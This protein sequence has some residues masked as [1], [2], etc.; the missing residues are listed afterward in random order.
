MTG[1][2]ANMKIDATGLPVVSEQDIIELMY[3]GHNSNELFV[4]DQILFENVQRAVKDL[5]LPM[6]FSIKMHEARTPDEMT[7]CWRLPEEYANIEIESW[8]ADRIST[9]EQALRVADEL[10]LYQAGGLYPLLR[11]LIYLVDTMRE[12]K[13]VWGV[14]RGSSVSSYCLFLIGIHKI[15]SMKYNLEI[16]EF[17]KWQNM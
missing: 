10:S 11:F 8:F 4:D 17:L 2:L 3:Q 6:P 9:E 15:D 14:G 5:A 16:K 13:I 12:H 1:L 7:N